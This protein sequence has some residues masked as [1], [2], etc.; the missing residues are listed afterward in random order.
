MFVLAIDSTRFQ[1]L[2]FVYYYTSNL[3]ESFE[4]TFLVPHTHTHTHTHTRTHTTQTESV[5]RLYFFKKKIQLRNPYTENERREFLYSKKKETHVH[6]NK[7]NTIYA[8][9]VSINQIFL[10]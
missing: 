2:L 4:S 8:V 9:V 5:Q 3:Y 7:K 1:V 10:V 6:T